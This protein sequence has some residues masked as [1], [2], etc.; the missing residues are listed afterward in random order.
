[1]SVRGMWS[2]LRDRIAALS[3][4]DRRALLIGAVIVVPLLAWA[5][6][7]RPY[8]RTL[9]DL[10]DRLAAEEALLVRERNV[11]RDAPNLPARLEAAGLDIAE[12]EACLISAANP[13]LAEA[14]ITALL[15]VLARRN[16]VLL[17]EVRAITP[18]LAEEPPEGV[19]PIY[20]SVSGESDFEG[21]LDFLSEVEHHP[22]LMKIHSLSMEPG[23]VEAAS[24]RGGRGGAQIATMTF[25]VMLEA[26][27]VGDLN[28]GQD[29]A[30]TEIRR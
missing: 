12:V 21:V 8:I 27:M 17:Q 6:V 11:L 24:G 30:E 20:L 19:L 18:P 16:L 2:R 3:S 26:F 10:R 5:G 1:M 22:L 15:E 13:A 7:V 9:D 29:A 25:D 4:R 14:D 23:A 28:T